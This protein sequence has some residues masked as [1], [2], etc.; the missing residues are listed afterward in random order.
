[1]PCQLFRL[2]Q[3]PYASGVYHI[4][5]PE[6][7][8]G[9]HGLAPRGFQLTESWRPVATGGDN[10]IGFRFRTDVGE[11]SG[12]LY[13][14]SPTTSHILLLDQEDRTCLMARLSAKPLGYGG[15]SIQVSTDMARAV[16]GW[17]RA[18]AVDG[19]TKEGIAAAILAG[20]GC[21]TEDPHLLMYRR[22]VLRP[23]RSTI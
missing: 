15:V 21:A 6:H 19:V 18:S 9:A 12:R 3:V 5:S 1:M 2:P 23:P 4:H 11:M 17:D 7:F 10:L 8:L 13:S 14:S 20:H 16:G 22:R